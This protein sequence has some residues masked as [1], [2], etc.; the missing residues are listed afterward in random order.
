MRDTYGQYI[1]RER[2]CQSTALGLL[3]KYNLAHS[4]AIVASTIEN[5]VDFSQA[6]T[7]QLQFE[8]RE[9]ENR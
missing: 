4:W 1:H 3:A 7:L 5:A 2:S 9:V 8:P 6:G